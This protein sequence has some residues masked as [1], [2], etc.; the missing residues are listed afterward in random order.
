[1]PSLDRVMPKP[2]DSPLRSN[3]FLAY[4]NP[5][6]GEWLVI[7][8]AAESATIA[9]SCEQNR[10]NMSS[11]SKL[12]TTAIQH[13]DRDRTNNRAKSIASTLSQYR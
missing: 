4:R 12:K 11:S 13:G 3:P 5:I 1:M 7:E 9:S 2:S 10:R 6:T 8:N